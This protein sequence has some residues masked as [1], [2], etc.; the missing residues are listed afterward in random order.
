MKQVKQK[1]RV[2]GNSSNPWSLKNILTRFRKS[3]IDTFVD[4]LTECIQRRVVDCYC[5]YWQKYEATMY[6]PSTFC[7]CKVSHINFHP[8]SSWLP[9]R[10]PLLYAARDSSMTRGILLAVCAFRE[11]FK[12]FQR[13]QSP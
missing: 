7:L 1:I 10:W 11:L 9:W 13:E 6:K 2:T 12:F 5:R 4:W 3:V 8:L